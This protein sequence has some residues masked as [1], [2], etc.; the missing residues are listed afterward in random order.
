MKTNKI[1]II[2]LALILVTAQ[3]CKKDKNT[4]PVSRSDNQ[5]SFNIYEE[6]NLDEY[7]TNFMGKMKT[8][9]R[10]GESLTTDD[11]MWHLSACL[12][13]TY[14]NINVNKSQ[15]EYDTIVTSINVDDGYITLNDINRSFNEISN[16][17]NA[18]YNS[19]T[20][21][22]KNILYV[23][24]ELQ[25][26][27]TRGGTT[28]RTVVAISNSLD[29]GHYFFSDEETALSLFPEYTTYLWNTEAI[30]TLTYY[31]N[32]YRSETEEIPGRVYI[33]NLTEVSC[34]YQNTYPNNRVFR[35]R[36]SSNLRLDRE[37]MAFFLDS[38]LG[39][40]DESNPGRPILGFVNF[41]IIPSH[42]REE[43]MYYHTLNIK[44]GIIRYTT[45]PT[46]P[47]S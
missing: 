42:N 6:K 9:T 22:N 13:F 32:L 21:E 12:N 33:T 5:T 45:T 24:P 39:L 15:V 29:F 3:S 17:V 14:S 40:I 43:V 23:I 38:Y 25:D 46:P 7:L 18:V 1:C 19:S 36:L 11:A 10:S 2:I 28:V 31:M 26:D 34:N 35:T 16:E 44:Y 41:D 47:A 20:L 30:E 27:V 8:N 4:D 37:D